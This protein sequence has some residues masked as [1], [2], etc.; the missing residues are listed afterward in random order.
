VRVFSVVKLGVIDVDCQQSLQSDDDER[1]REPDV[2]PIA[3][4]DPAASKRRRR[5]H[6][7]KSLCLFVRIVVFIPDAP[8]CAQL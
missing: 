2:R 5:E 3:H 4:A 7:M 8:V 6:E 1:R